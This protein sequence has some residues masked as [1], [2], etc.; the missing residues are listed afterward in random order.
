MSARYRSVKKLNTIDS[1]SA[2]F[3]SENGVASRLL[4]FNV[5][6]PC[7]YALTKNLTYES[8]GGRVQSPTSQY[9]IISAAVPYGDKGD[10]DLV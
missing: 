4:K 10:C 3:A 6:N 2:G 5:I 8:A 9:P 1:Y 7:S